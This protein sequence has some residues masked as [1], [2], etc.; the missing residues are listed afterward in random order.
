[1]SEGHAVAVWEDVSRRRDGNFSIGAAASARKH[2]GGRKNSCKIAWSAEHSWSL[3]NC[4]PP[5][6]P[7]E[8]L[9][10]LRRPIRSNIHYGILI[11]LSRLGL[12]LLFILSPFVQSY[13]IIIMG[14]WLSLSQSSFILSKSSFV[15]LHYFSIH[16]RHCGFKCNTTSW[17]IL[18]W[19]CSMLL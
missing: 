13:T 14:Q 2:S 15:H 1:M 7:M 18:L 6:W 4:G 10:C 8:S 9:F 16:W 3:Q 11:C 5:E 19:I 12:P 17:E